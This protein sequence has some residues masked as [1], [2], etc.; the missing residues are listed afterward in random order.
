MPVH[1]EKRGNKYRIVEPG[2]KIAKTSKGSARDGGGHTSKAKASAQVRA[3]NQ[4]RRK[5]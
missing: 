3:I 5:R 2:G 1:V 4:N